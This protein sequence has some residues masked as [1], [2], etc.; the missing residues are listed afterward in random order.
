MTKDQYLILFEKYLSGKASPQEIE[1]LLA[2]RDDFDL[3]EGEPGNDYAQFADKEERILNKLESNILTQKAPANI[4]RILLMA[5]SVI[6]LIAVGAIFLLK[7]ESANPLLSKSKPAINNDIKPA[8]HNALLTLANGKKVILNNL[9]VG[10]VLRH[11]NINVKKEANGLLKI[12]ASAKLPDRDTNPEYNTISTPVGGHYEVVLP[13]GS[14]VWLNAASS[15]KFPSAFTGNE[16]KVELTGEAYFE[17]AKNKQLPF[18]VKFDNQLVEVLGT[19]FNIKAYHNEAASTTTLLEG[20][21]SI[22]KDNIKKILIPG[23]QAV[24]A[25]GQNSI[26]VSAADEVAAVAWT[27]NVFFFRNENIRAIMRELSRWYDIDVVYQGNTA[28][29]DYGIRMSKSKNL[30][31]ILKNLELTGTIHFKVDERRVTVM[32]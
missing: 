1:A 19:H 13:D 31:E 9:M 24:S 22:S 15:L 4:R 23:E 11:G 6:L 20:S 8:A 28:H 12:N 26:M 29:K 10:T 17:V 27:N 7:S 30:S 16:R 32:E 18:K 3:I 21:V 25:S 14:K 5:A 2:Y